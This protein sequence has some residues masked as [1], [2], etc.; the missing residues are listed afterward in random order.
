MRYEKHKSVS[1]FVAMTC[2][3]IVAFIFERLYTN[4]AHLP[5]FPV[6]FSSISFYRAGL[7]LLLF[8]FIAAHFVVK[9]ST[10]YNLLFKYRYVVA[11]SLF[12]ILV[13]NQI[14][15]SSVGMYN[16][17][18][19]PGMG[20]EFASP[21]FGWPRYVRSDEWMMELPLV[22][23]AQ[24]GPEA[25]GSINYIFRGTATEQAIFGISIGLNTIGSPFDLFYLLGDVYGV[26]ARWVGLLLLSFMTSF[27]LFYIISKKNRLLAVVGA[28]MI[29]FS[30]FFQWWS[31]VIYVPAG[32]G[33]L[34]CFYYFL[35]TECRK[36]RVLLSSGIGIFASM[37]VVRLYPPWQV[38]VGYVILGIAI[39]MIYDN[40]TKI[41]QLK[42]WDI[43]I[44][45]ISLV[46]VAISVSSLILQSREFISAIMN[47]YYPGNRRVSGGIEYFGPFAVLQLNRLLNGGFFAGGLFVGG[48]SPESGFQMFLSTNVSEFSGMY[49]LFPV[50]FFYAI[51]LLAKKRFFDLL[52]AILIILSVIKFTYVFIGWPGFLSQ[53]TFMSFSVIQRVIDVILILQVFIFIRVI[54][55]LRESKEKQSLPNSYLKINILAVASAFSLILLIVAYEF[56]KTTFIVPIAAWY[57]MISFIGITL[58]F[59]S[60]FDSQMNKHIFKAACM[61]LILIT[62]VSGLSANP[63]M[64]GLDAIHSKP[65]A[66]KV[67]ELAIDTDEKWISLHSFVA[68]NF[69]AAS[70]ASTINSTNFYPNMD[71][72]YLFDLNREYAYIYNRYAHINVTLIT[73]S[74]T[75]TII[76]ADFFH[77]QLYYGDLE[78]M[79]VRFIHS[80]HMLEDYDNIMFHLIYTEGGHHIFY[81]CYDNDDECGDRFSFILV[82]QVTATNNTEGARIPIGELVEGTRREVSFSSDRNYA[83]DVHSFSI[84]FATHARDN[85]GTVRVGLYTDDELTFEEFVDF[86]TVEDNTHRYFYLDNSVEVHPDSRATIV[87]DV[88]AGEHGQSITAWGDENGDFIFTVYH[89][90]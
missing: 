41:K 87:L 84:F 35:N 3:F 51:F 85:Y 16:L 40:W 44:L 79:G 25:F 70:G 31:Y 2:A 63:V 14:S 43:A 20:S 86:S 89:Y 28:C 12:I 81:V 69:L 57:Y 13:L 83:V 49:T 30:P 29:V 73:E 26:S 74:T 48:F 27:E 82:P 75:F 38:S 18:I 62:A 10:L 24:Y 6:E 66:E 54:C 47:T 8:L 88:V 21:I 15:F 64:R 72:W 32:F 5:Q 90:R 22:L 33:V 80:A 76:Q 77:L 60:L 55:L 71:L 1:V 68:A 50:P 37:Y 4:F 65:L 59:Y 53:I 61:F 23:S 56:S 34:V 7:L 19:Q 36:K 67:R 46:L 58:V 17:H 45:S 9:F 52:T 42:K 39:W 78:A 11:V